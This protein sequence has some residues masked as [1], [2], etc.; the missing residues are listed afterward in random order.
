MGNKTRRGFKNPHRSIYSM[1]QDRLSGLWW[2]LWR[3]LKCIFVT[4]LTIITIST[5]ISVISNS[6]I[7][8]IT[9]SIS[10]SWGSYYNQPPYLVL[11]ISYND[12]NILNHGY[13]SWRIQI[14]SY[15]DI[16][17]HQYPVKFKFAIALYCSWHTLS[18]IKLSYNS[19]KT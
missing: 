3:H 12:F 17:Y 10:I 18:Q 4:T 19:I 9:P 2:A 13:Q 11:C 1:Y 8:S 14:W 16:D 7:S 5:I 15:L 6:T